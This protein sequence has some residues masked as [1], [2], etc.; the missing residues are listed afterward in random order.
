MKHIHDLASRVDGVVRHW[1]AYLR[2][3]G[4]GPVCSVGSGGSMD[5]RKHLILLRGLQGSGKSTFANFLKESTQEKFDTKIYHFEADQYFRKPDGNYV[6]RP[7]ELP[8]AHAY[9]Q[10]AT[11][12]A[13]TDGNTDSLYNEVIV[14]VSNTFSQ[15]W[16]MKPYI[17]MAKEQ[18]ARLTILTVE[19]T[20]SDEELAARNA[21]HC[22]ADAITRV[23]N[24]WECLTKKD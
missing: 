14:I 12:Q 4:D 22:P 23:R 2:E 5:T 16:E 10:T 11:R 7:E 20:L 21:N 18:G 17:E 13:L 3:L 24:R 15:M 8:K 1:R 19:T 6:F 9:C